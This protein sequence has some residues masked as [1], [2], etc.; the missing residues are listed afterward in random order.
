MATGFGTDL[1]H[2]GEEG[3]KSVRG[4]GAKSHYRHGGHV[5]AARLESP[6]AAQLDRHPRHRKGRL[7]EGGIGQGLDGRHHLFDVDI[8]G[9]GALGIGYLDGFV[10]DGLGQNHISGSRHGLLQGCIGFGCLGFVEDQIKDNHRRP[11]IVQAVDEP[12]VNGAGPVARLHGKAKL[13][14]GLAVERHDDHIFGRR[15]RPA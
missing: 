6:V 13:L 11:G 14:G 7:G 3:I 4:E 10:D 9:R 8:G 15:L 5:A 1:A 2:Q 12:G